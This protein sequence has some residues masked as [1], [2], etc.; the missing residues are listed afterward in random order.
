MSSNRLFAKPACILALLLMCF[1]AIY[2]KPK[3]S[4]AVWYVLSQTADSKTENGDVSIGITT[5][6]ALP[7]AYSAQD[8]TPYSVWIIIIGNDSDEM[9]YVDLAQCFQ[10]FNMMS[11]SMYVPSATAVS[12]GASASVGSS[13]FGIGGRFGGGVTGMVTGSTMNTV[14]S[15]SQQVIAIPPKSM[16]YMPDYNVLPQEYAR[17]YSDFATFKKVGMGQYAGLGIMPV[18]IK[19]ARGES[20]EYNEDNTPMKLGLYFTYFKNSEMKDPQV[21]RT[22]FYISREIGTAYSTSPF[23]LLQEYDIVDSVDP[24]VQSEVM[25][26]GHGVIRMWNM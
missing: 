15:Y 1:S 4:T 7:M 20:I 22:N 8:K 5:K 19:A 18:S 11:V 13:F 25:Q 9:V 14:V 3:K 17:L 2:A 6:V 16:Y 26:A 10:I 12:T 24:N 21:I 23:N